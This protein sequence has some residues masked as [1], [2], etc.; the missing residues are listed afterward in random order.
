MTN[1]SNAFK[2]RYLRQ[3]NFFVG[4]VLALLFTNIGCKHIE[5]EAYIPIEPEYYHAS[6]VGADSCTKCHQKEHEEWKNSH[7]D[8]AMKLADSTTILA[9]FDNTSFVH[10]GVKSSFFRKGQDFF[11][12]TEGEDGTYQDFK[13]VYTYGVSPLQQYI[14]AFPNGEFNCLLTAWDTKEEKWFH[15]QPDLEI[16]H[17]EW[18]NWS[19]GSQRWNTMCADCHS[20][21]LKKN[22][23]LSSG[24]YNTTFSE[25]NVACEACHGPASEHVSYYENTMDAA[26]KSKAP[27]QLYMDS[28]MSSL[29]V[30]DKC[31]RCHARRTNLTTYFDY[32]GAFMDHYYPRML[33][34]PLYELDG[35]IKDE[36]YVYSSFIQS[37][38]YQEGVSCNDCHNAHS[39]QLKREGNDLC[40]SCHTPNYNTTA[41]HFHPMNTEAALCINCH[42]DGKLYMV[43]DY[44]RDHSFRI[45]RPD[46]SVD[47]NT[48]NACNKCHTEESAE[49]A[50]SFIQENYGPERA[51]HFSD[52]LLKGYTGDYAAFKKVFSNKYYPD[53]ARATAIGRYAD[54]PI[55]AEEALNL[56]LY[57]NDSSVFVRNETVRALERIGNPAFSDRIVPMLKDS[58]RVV[59]ISAVHYFH[60]LGTA[61][62]KE[63]EAFKKAD[64]EYVEE[65]NVNSDFP[66]GLH[67]LAIYEQ[68]QGNSEKAIEYYQRAIAEDSYNNRSRMNLALLYYQLGRPE[69][70]EALY[71][72]V[73]E[74]E[75]EF[76]Y[77]YYMLGLLYNETGDSTKAGSYLS[78][79][80]TLDPPNLNAFYNYALLLQQQKKN[81]ASLE[82]IEK[83][84]AQFPFNERLVYIKL[85]GQLNLNLRYEALET[86]EVLLQLNP[87][88]ADY[89]QLKKQ[90][91]GGV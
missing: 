86:L 14:V 6:F 34:E 42:M 85:L 87:A 23:D 59:R 4:V 16:K 71:L 33:E 36:V 53:I 68:G 77:V 21:D 73:I 20:T 44:R 32:K 45:P 28:E 26:E 18:I 31:A 13:I 12:N 17:D 22:Y 69:E 56:S 1:F 11:V 24:V 25:I 60:T 38:M 51:D 50:A 35:Q 84:L 29:D 5:K 79:A 41:H 9:D 78:K 62:V 7:H 49:W 15:L 72:K 61:S 66:A 8:M 90:L 55:T 39:L 3:K 40:L 52:H 76:S 64:K 19:G 54:S 37:K 81:E 58:L 82:I 43:N 70:S 67:Q 74:Q 75:P 88:N 89:I 80:T 47:Y 2:I 48:P 46:Q 83:G 10:N 91:E 27:P 65:L 30:V 63:L 57:L